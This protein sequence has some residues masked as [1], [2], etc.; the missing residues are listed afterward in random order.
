MGCSWTWRWTLGIKDRGV[1]YLRRTVRVCFGNVGMSKRSGILRR[2]SGAVSVS[3]RTFEQ[4]VGGK[5]GFS[6]VAFRARIFQR[7]NE[8]TPPSVSIT[9]I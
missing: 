5:N 8:D 4:I 6:I 3:K 1:E 7:I 2:D 9:C